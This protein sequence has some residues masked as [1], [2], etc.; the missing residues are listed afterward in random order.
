ME[1][2]GLPLCLCPTARLGWGWEM[3]KSNVHLDVW[4]RRPQRAGSLLFPSTSAGCLPGGSCPCL[5]RELLGAEFS[6]GGVHAQ[7]GGITADNGPGLLG[8]DRPLSMGGHEEPFS[9][10]QH[11]REVSEH[12]QTELFRVSHV[13]IYVLKV[14]TFPRLPGKDGEF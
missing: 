10:P 11:V 6:R 1:R 7:L 3:A 12:A 14:K 8:S 5:P 4:G 2:K 13:L 9:A